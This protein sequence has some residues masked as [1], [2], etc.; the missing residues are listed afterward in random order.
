MC[1]FFSSGKNEK[2][3][4]KP[5]AQLAQWEPKYPKTYLAA[6]TALFAG[7]TAL[8]IY[9]GIRKNKFNTTNTTID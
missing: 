1:S 2:R 4:W 9:S 8:A 7:F 3:A 5:L 6:S